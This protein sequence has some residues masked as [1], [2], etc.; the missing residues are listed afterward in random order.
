MIFCQ[1]KFLG[2]ART[3]V[4]GSGWIFDRSGGEVEQI[5]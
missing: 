4:E 5:Y 1:R 2:K 3:D